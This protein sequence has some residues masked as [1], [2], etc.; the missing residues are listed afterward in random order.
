MAEEK[1][2]T[3]VWEGDATDLNRTVTGINQRFDRLE[4]KTQRTGREMDK[5]TRAVKRSDR[6]MIG[7]S[8]SIRTTPPGRRGLPVW[9]WSGWGRVSR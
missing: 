5:T 9:P 1:T 4:D 8:K 3:Y 2:I 7:L 6:S